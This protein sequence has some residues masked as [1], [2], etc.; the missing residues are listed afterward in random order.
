MRLDDREDVV[1]VMVHDL[2]YNRKGVVSFLHKNGMRF[3]PN[4]SDTEIS[5]RLYEFLVKSDSNKERYARYLVGGEYHNF[6]DPISLYLIIMATV[7]VTTAIV[8]AVKKGKEDRKNLARL[9]R[10]DISL[11]EAKYASDLESRR[12]FLTNVF[13]TQQQMLI[14]DENSYRKAESLKKISIT[15]LIIT[16]LL[17]G[18]IALRLK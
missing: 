13:T 10:Q 1:Y 2:T 18:V 11:E 3:S 8:S 17:G 5:E 16:V 12:L 4:P 6:I 14:D 15:A 9:N 7:S